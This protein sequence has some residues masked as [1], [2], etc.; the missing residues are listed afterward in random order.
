LSKG[1][2]KHSPESLSVAVAAG[3]KSPTQG[4][5]GGGGFTGCGKYEKASF[6]TF[7]KN[8]QKD[9]SKH[10]PAAREGKPASPT[11]ASVVSE[12]G[13]PSA[14]PVAASPV[15][16]DFPVHVDIPDV[17]IQAQ[18][19]DLAEKHAEIEEKAAFAKN[20]LKELTSKDRTYEFLKTD[21]V[22]EELRKENEMI[23][24]LNVAMSSLVSSG[25][26]DAAQ[27]AQA[28]PS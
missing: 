15:P 20:S 1:C 18:F 4:G 25:K 21:G 10:T 17:V 3:A 16:E 11:P 23:E 14:S 7:C 8:C 22:L 9:L 27:E 6:G 24:A 28:A 12:D 2:K 26:E 5:G 13:S 19:Q